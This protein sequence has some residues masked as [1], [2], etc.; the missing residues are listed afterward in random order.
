MSVRFLVACDL[1]PTNPW[2]RDRLP[3]IEKALDGY[4]HSFVDIY[5][6]DSRD[7]AYEIHKIRGDSYFPGTDLEEINR[8]F[9]ERVSSYEFDVLILGTVDNYGWFLFPETVEKLRSTGAYVVGILGDDE[10]TAQNNRL[11]IPVF[12]KVIAYVQGCVDY[13]NSIKSDCC[14]H[15]PNS[16]FFPERNFSVLQMGEDEKQ[17][18]VTMMGAPFGI[19]PKLVQALHNAGVNVSLFGSPKWLEYAELST[20][21]GGYLPNEQVDE[22]IRSSKIFLAFLEDHLTGALHMNT[23]IW[24]AV[25]NGQMCIT[26]RYSPLTEDYGFVEN[27][28]IVMY[29]SPEDLVEKVRYYLDHPIERL[30]IAENLFNKV[31]EH[32]DYEELYRNLF[33]RLEQDVLQVKESTSGSEFATSPCVTIIDHSKNGEIHPGFS[34]VRAPRGS[35]WRQLLRDDFKR[36]VQTPYVVMSYGDSSYSPCLNDVLELFPEELSDGKVSLSPVSKRV[37]DQPGPLVDVS[38][39]VWEKDVFYEQFLSARSVFGHRYR[40]S[41]S[42]GFGNL[43]LVR[44]PSSILLNVLALFQ[45]IG[46]GLRRSVRSFTRIFNIRTRRGYI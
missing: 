20:H 37:E 35:G 32:F 30:R 29:D 2:K 9:Y 21:Y 40:R 28:D 39:I 3:A 23:K 25:R 43:R 18:D 11:Y 46:L 44:T 8:K 26:T 17:H 24:D 38:S 27:E 12:D 15:L 42:H 4:N 13:Y 1:L 19:R 14:Y 34:V 41:K 36:L 22:V 45:K 7:E 33:Q 31:K 16:C 5:E 6:F 10:W